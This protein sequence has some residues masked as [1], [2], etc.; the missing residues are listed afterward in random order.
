MAREFAVVIYGA[1]GAAGFRAAQHLQARHATQ[2]F[3]WALAGRA[4]ARLEQMSERFGAEPPTLVADLADRTALNQL[5]ARSDV[6]L[7]LAGPYGGVAT[8]LIEACIEQRTHYVDLCGENACLRRLIERFHA[9]AKVNGV[10]VLPSAGYESVPFDIGTL[11]LAEKLRAR[12]GSRCAA[13]D[14]EVRFT[15]P[16]AARGGLK[17]T[18]G[19]LRTMLSLMRRDAGQR[20]LDPYHFSPSAKPAAAERE[21]NRILLDARRSPAGH[22]LAP[23]APNPFLN[24]ATVQRSRA[25]L[26]A[27]ADAPY[28]TPFSYHESI[29]LSHGLATPLSRL[30]AMPMARSLA[31]AMQRIAA[32]SEGRNGWPDRAQRAL[33]EAALARAAH[34]PEDVGSEAM[35][36]VL[37]FSAKTA[38]DHELRAEM[39][40]K[41]DPGYVST[42]R[43]AAEAALALAQDRDHKRLPANYGVVTPASALGPAFM[44]RFEHIGIE[45]RVLEAPAS[46]VL[47]APP[48]HAGASST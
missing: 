6:V 39:T 12:F 46:V 10:K 43:I 45:W 7:N 33:F 11:E 8:R 1:T 16:K 9:R 20:L 40:I 30:W 15:I 21:A 25:L 48:L 34:A 24:P 35:S 36:Y 27:H 13:V 47:A 32:M 2:S 18:R 28:D 38:R 3:G 22:W 37:A 5:A 29:N 42:G 26:S 31:S 44:Q 41:G 19:F 17:N 23:L 14:V 4:R